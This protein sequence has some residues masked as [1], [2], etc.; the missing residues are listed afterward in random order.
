MPDP[1][2]V[3]MA[4][5]GVVNDSGDLFAGRDGS[6][7]LHL[8]VPVP[9]GAPVREDLRSRGVVIERNELVVGGIRRPFAD[10]VCHEPALND[11]FERL[12]SEMVS[13]V[14]DRPGD[15]VTVC[16]EVLSRWRELLERRRTALGADAVAGLFGELLTLSRIV[17]LDPARRVDVWTGPMGAKHDFSSSGTAAEVKTT[18][19]R[20]GRFVEIH[21]VEQL[22]PVGLEELFLVFIRIESK[23]EGRTVGEL[24]ASL[25]QTGVDG[26]RLDRLVTQTGWEAAA[27]DERLSVVEQR[28]Y[29]VDEG[30]PRIVASSF[31]AGGLPAGVLRL[32][33]EVDL[34]GLSPAPMD[35]AS[36]EKV[37]FRLATE[38]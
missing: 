2:E 7:R 37:F 12:A 15:S 33:Y 34:T 31:A 4:S 21:G 22:Q 11:V 35:T 36:S 18:R 23:P 28:I 38:R 5:L 9:L 25:K 17:G 24:I 8:L 1:G 14:A 32:R 30:F 27:D 3:K 6:G 20:E 16:Q 13:R 19:R 10:V 26:P 29:R